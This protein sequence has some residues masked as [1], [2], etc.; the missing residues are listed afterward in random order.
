MA[1]ALPYITAAASVASVASSIS[2]ASA[3]KKSIA[4]QKRI[5]D[6]NTARERVQAA[7]ERR[8]ATSA[9]LASAGNEGLGGSGVQG[10]T[11]SIGSQYGGNIA[12]INTMQTF[13]AQASAANQQ[14][15]DAN[16]MANSWQAIGGLSSSMTDWKSIFGGNATGTQWPPAPIQD[17][18]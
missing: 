2:S 12:N 11:A 18:R 1:V 15:A 10:A 5:A 4:A 14:A 6:V 9:I 8:I 3:Q 17:R 16:A 13:G 7:R